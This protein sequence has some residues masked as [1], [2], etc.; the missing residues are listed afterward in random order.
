MESKKPTTVVKSETEE[1][2]LNEK[3]KPYFSSA[4]DPR[5]SEEENN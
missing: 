2:R 5:R 3:E 1:K 4:R